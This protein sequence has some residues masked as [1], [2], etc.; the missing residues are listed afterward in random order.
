MKTLRFCGLVLFFVLVSLSML[1]ACKPKVPDLP[2]GQNEP[3]FSHDELL[4]TAAMQLTYSYHETQFH[5]PTS[6]PTPM[7]TATHTPPLPTFIAT[8]AR[9]PTAEISPTDEKRVTVREWACR[10]M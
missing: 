8:I 7:F 9:T 5:L 3:T 4:Q 10:L 1:V 6:T 2:F